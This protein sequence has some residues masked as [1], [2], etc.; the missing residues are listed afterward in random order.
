MIVAGV[1]CKRGTP[2]PEI[3]GAVRAALKRANIGA[4]A[5]D[6]IA[7]IAAKQD[8]AGILAA[9]NTLGVAVVV[10]SETDCRAASD[11]TRTRSQRSLAHTGLPSAAES[12]ALAAAGP[13]AEL[14]GERLVVGAATCALAASPDGVRPRTGA[15]S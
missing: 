10:M 12:A 1:G 8:E 11:R 14:L 13:A 2:A 7:T 15:Q 9:A 5:L 6:A 4:D 3:E